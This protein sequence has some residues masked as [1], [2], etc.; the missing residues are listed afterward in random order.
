M[1]PTNL[2]FLKWIDPYE[3]KEKHISDSIKEENLR[4]RKVLD[5]S[6]SKSDIDL[7]SKKNEIY[8]NEGNPDW[9]L[10]Y[11]INNPKISFQLRQI[12]HSYK[13]KWINKGGWHEADNIDISKDGKYIAYTYADSYKKNYKL[14]VRGGATW[15]H[16]KYGGPNV[17]I[18]GSR[19]FFIEGDEFLHYNRLVSIDLDTG[20]DRKVV[21]EEPSKTTEIELVLCE[22]RTLFLLSSDSGI[23]SLYH[24]LPNEFYQLSPRG[25]SFYPVGSY[26][27]APIY[28]VREGKFSAPWKFIGGCKLNSRI[29]ADG[30]E[31]CSYS[32]KILITKFYGMRTIWKIGNEPILKYSGIFEVNANM[33]YIG[34]LYGMC[35][36][37]RCIRPGSSPFAI[38]LKTGLL[39]QPKITYG[40]ELTTGISVSSDQLPVRWALLKPQTSPIGLICISYGAYGIATTLNTSRWRAWTDAG[41]AIAI[42][43]IRGGGDGNDMWADLGRLGGKKKEIDDVEACVRSLQKLTGCKAVNTILFGRSAGGL[44]VGN[45]AARHPK[46]ELAGTIYTEVPYVDLL[47]TAANPRLPLTQYEYKEFGNPRAGLIDFELAFEISPIHQLG[48]R[49]APGIKVLCRSGTH[50]TQVYPYESLKWITALRGGKKDDTKI[51]Y[52]DNEG[53]TSDKRFREYAEDFATIMKWIFKKVP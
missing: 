7:L 15:T 9:I 47:K 6:A 53:H 20:R 48:P 16:N 27:N 26:K 4:F 3:E 5:A 40:G 2:G 44:I 19:V 41:W 29:C 10:N 17:A 11:P 23:Q 42:L 31:F 18:L 28:F 33:R 43:F 12:D 8:L 14:S 30:I 24:I 34:W 51:L 37:I 21:F 13:W 25:V 35:D 32:A 22:S 36:K 46:G 1:D 52:I 50:D 49:G 38:Y 45:L 39:G